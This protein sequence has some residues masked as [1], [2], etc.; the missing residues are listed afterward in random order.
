MKFKVKIHPLFLIFACVLVAFSKFWLLLCYVVTIVLH[1]LA[2][3][4]V[5]KSRGYRLNQYTFMP[6]GISLS[7]E[8]VLFTKKDEIIIALAGPLFNLA[9]A[10]VFIAIWWIFP[11]SYAFTQEFVFA[12]LITCFVNFLPIFPMDGGRVMLAILSKKHSRKK[13]VLILKWFGVAISFVFVVLFVVSTFFETNFT[14]LFLG[15]FIFLTV[16]WE[17]KTNIYIKTSFLTSK[18]GNI[19]RGLIIREIAISEDTSLYKLICQTNNE[20]I[21]NFKVFNDKMNVVGTI[22]EKSLEKFAQIYP[23]GTPIKT[24]LS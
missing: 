4:V 23:A 17:D 5:A 7:G 6:H 3:A 20:S 8:N 19:K 10:T 14:L 11:V 15:V 22:E 24:I 9:I 18:K 21:T 1:E 12:N 16:L 13:S 2:H